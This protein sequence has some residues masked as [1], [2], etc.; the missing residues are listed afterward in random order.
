MKKKY[1]G[2]KQ[3]SL[4][5]PDQSEKAFYGRRYY[6]GA[7]LRFSLMSFKKAGAKFVKTDNGYKQIEPV[8]EKFDKLMVKLG[9]I[10]TQKA[11]EVEKK[12]DNKEKDREKKEKAEA[13]VLIKDA[14]RIWLEHAK[15]DGISK[16]TIEKFYK[17]MMKK[18]FAINENHLL[19]RMNS[20]H[21][22]NFKDSLS[23]NENSFLKGAKNPPKTALTSR[24]VYLKQLKVFLNW[25]HRTKNNKGFRYLDEIQTVTFFP[26][27]QKLPELYSEDEVIRWLGHLDNLLS[28]DP[29]S[30]NDPAIKHNPDKRQKRYI[31]MHKRLLYLF[32]G[33]GFRLSEAAF[34]EWDQIDFE[35]GLITLRS[36]PEFGF[37]IK[38]KKQSIRPILPDALAYLETQKKL[39]PDEKYLLDNNGKPAFPATDAIST[40]FLRYRKKLNMNPKAKAVH[41]IRAFFASL[42]EH[43]GIDGYTIQLMMGHSSFET[44]QIYLGRPSERIRQA[45]LVMNKG[46]EK[47][48][49][50][51]LNE[52]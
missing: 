30:T 32:I 12:F 38:E 23:K 9:K 15:S 16:T 43:H 45:I 47:I 14:M 37:K 11:I 44:T 35:T 27:E 17:P 2:D 34:L 40:A 26:V 20:E 3:K 18:Y 39:Y 48:F 10:Y 13:N 51:Q 29:K 50:N 6:K 22:R 42:A 5:Y 4:M 49:K 24:N 8:G 33:T 25:A 1:T 46:A 7:R 36:K 21:V 19:N 28:K 52:L 31:L 41:S